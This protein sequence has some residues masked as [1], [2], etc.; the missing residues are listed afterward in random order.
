MLRCR[1]TFYLAGRERK[2]EAGIVGVALKA[3]YAEAVRSTPL[4]MLDLLGEL[5]KVPPVV[6]TEKRKID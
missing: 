5:G 3:I 1:R 4:D 6:V 2:L